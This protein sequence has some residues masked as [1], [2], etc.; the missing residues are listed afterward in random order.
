MRRTLA[1]ML[2]ERFYIQDR[3]LGMDILQEVVDQERDSLIIRRLEST[4]RRGFIGRN[5][6]GVSLS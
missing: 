3:I 2:H 1:A 4:G 6:L 5:H